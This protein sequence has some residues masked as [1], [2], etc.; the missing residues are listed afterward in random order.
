MSSGTDAL[1]A[2]SINESI[3]VKQSLLTDTLLLNQVADVIK[4]FVSALKSGHKIL[5][6]GN[7][8]SAHA[9]SDVHNKVPLLRP[10]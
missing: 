9:H 8:G 3:R 1:I 4:E 2:D 10:C 5:L 6:F 7:G